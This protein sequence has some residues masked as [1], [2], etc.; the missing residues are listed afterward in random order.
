MGK[1][2]K[3]QVISVAKTGMKEAEAKLVTFSKRHRF[4]VVV[5]LMWIVG[6]AS[7]VFCAFATFMGTQMMKNDSENLFIVRRGV[8]TE[9]QMMPYDA[10]R[11]EEA[12]EHVTRFHK[13]FFNLSQSSTTNQQNIE[14]A[15]KLADESAFA[16]FSDLAEKKYYSRLVA[17]NGFQEIQ[18]DTV[19]TD[20]DVYP[21]K[22]C[23]KGTIFVLDE[24]DSVTTFTFRSTG[25]L[26]D[27][28]RSR[29]NL[30]GFLICN[31]SMI[32]MEQL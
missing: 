15:L 4:P 2:K 29:Y 24:K 7:V 9:G 3:E 10:K 11:Q 19:I 13:L 31:Y 20:M 1:N 8:A 6:I 26:V 18:I 12:V 23:T 16:Y 30:N 14:R 32:N 5:P 25:V 28:P 27:V 22:V 21:Y 17:I